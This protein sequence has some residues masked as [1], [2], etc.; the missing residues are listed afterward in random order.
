MAL[1]IENVPLKLVSLGSVRPPVVRDR[2][3]EDVGDGDLR[4]A[5]AA[6]LPQGLRGDGR[7]RGQRGGAA[8]RLSRHHPAHR[9][10][11]RLGPG[12]PGRPAGGRAHH[13]PHRQVRAHAVRREP[14]ED[15]PLDPDPEAGAH[16][17]E[18][19]ARP[20]PA[21]RAAGPRLRGRGGEGGAGGGAHRRAAEPHPGDG[22]RV[23][24]AAL[25]RGGAEQR[26]RRREHG[27]RRPP[28]A[29]PG[30]PARPRHRAHPGGRRASGSWTACPS[31]CA[32]ARGRSVRRPCG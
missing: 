27:P 5:R 6:E 26:Q 18:G 25:D 9:S 11:R 28:P 2:G 1:L 12:G 24:G 3:R 17:A 20:S 32:A 22:E 16:A 30:Q 23:H 31:R 21:G 14:R 13:P 8:A 10:R 4:S 29:R 15:H 7:A 19:G